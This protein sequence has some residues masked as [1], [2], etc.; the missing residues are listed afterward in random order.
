M[1]RGI[2][3]VLKVLS[4]RNLCMIAG[5]LLSYFRPTQCAISQKSSLPIWLNT[6]DELL[7]LLEDSHHPL[8]SRFSACIL[9]LVDSFVVLGASISRTFARKRLMA[10]SGTSTLGIILPFV[11]MLRMTLYPRKSK[12]SVMWVTFVLSS[13]SVSP[14]VLRNPLSS[15]LMAWASAF[16]PLHS[17]TSRV[18]RGSLTPA[19]SQIRAGTARLTR[20][21]SS[22]RRPSPHLPMHEEA[23]LPL[24]N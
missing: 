21:L 3:L 17:T 23:R 20:L 10:F 24:G 13:E 16:V 2:A 19:P 14:R 22:S 15:S 18:A 11:P 9:A 5:M 6:Q 8:V 1:T 7:G 12:P 4:F